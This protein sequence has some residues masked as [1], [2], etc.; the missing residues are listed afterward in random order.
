MSEAQALPVAVAT[1]PRLG[2]IGV[3]WIGRHRLEVLLGSH[4]AVIAAVADSDAGALRLALHAAPGAEAVTGLDE[5][6][7]CDLDGVVIATPSALHAAQAQAAL[8][9]GIAVFCQKP[10]ARTAAEAR[11]VVECAAAADRLLGVDFSY[12]YVRGMDTVRQLIQSGELGTIYAADLTFHN[13]YGPDKPWFYDMAQAGGGCAMDLG[14]HLIDL[15]L[16]LLD[17]PEVTAVHSRL[18]RQGRQLVKPV[19]EVEDYAIANL[20][21]ATGTHVRLACSWQ[22]SAGCDAVIEAAFYGTRGGIVFYNVNGSFY[23]FV[24]ERLAGTSRQRLAAYPDAWGGR[25]L[26]AWAAQL[27]TSRRFDPEAERLITVSAVLDEVYGR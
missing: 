18:Y 17:F 16:W 23:D 10:L 11:A 13:A 4:S 3:G 14:S 24:I 21:L 19:A 15:A 26:C 6:L 1:R 7:D 27:A 5:L 25:A 8:A 9:R 22:L 12:R 2:F 20:D